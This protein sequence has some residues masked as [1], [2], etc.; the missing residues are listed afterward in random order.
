MRSK[1]VLVKWTGSKRIQAPSIIKHFP[2]SI[3]T[4][5]EPF[6]GGGSMLYVLMNSDIEVGKFEC[7]DLNADLIDVWKTIKE[8]P[9]SIID[10]YKSN[11]QQ[12]SREVYDRIRSEHNDSPDPRKFFFLLRT[13]RN[14][15]V[16]YNKY[17]KF[18]SAFHHGRR[19][20]NPDQLE[21][22]V[23]DWHNKLIE[24]DVK[25]T[26]R[27]YKDVKSKAGDLLYLDPP[28]ARST[29][30]NMYFLGAFDFESFW[31]WL[32]CQQSSYLVSL[33]GF[34]GNKDCRVDFPTDLYDSHELI[35]NGL[36]K[37]DQM[38]HNHVVAQD[39]LYIKVMVAA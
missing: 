20:V 37:F 7:S 5:Y 34:K 27:D 30:F 25:F 4:Y 24:H 19:G 11:W 29:T 23:M 26:V 39:S 2:K 1:D 3:S 38:Q 9:R 10:F 8:D 31:N 35:A 13:C 14:G 15:L 33:N 32:R 16:R 17:K 18:N 28:Y 21:E 36:N 6:L 12:V 22:T